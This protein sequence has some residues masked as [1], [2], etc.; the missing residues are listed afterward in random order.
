MGAGCS[1]GS[2]QQRR[3][4]AGGVGSGG[5][6]SPQDNRTAELP[7]S[8]PGSAADSEDWFAVGGH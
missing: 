2:A 8:S 6:G 3:L 1:A 7:A 5:V 4:A